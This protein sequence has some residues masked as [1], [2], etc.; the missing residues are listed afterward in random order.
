MIFPKS[1]FR[2][3][4]NW[5]PW[6]SLAI[7]LKDINPYPIN[8]PS[9]IYPIYPIN[10]F[11]WR[12][13]IHQVYPSSPSCALH[14]PQ[15]VPALCRRRGDEKGD[16]L[17]GG[18]QEPISEEGSAW[19]LHGKTCHGLVGLVKVVL[20]WEFHHPNWLSYFSEGLKPST[21]G[22]KGGFK[23]GVKSG[24]NEKCIMMEKTEKKNVAGNWF[25][26]HG[27]NNM[28]KAVMVNFL[29]SSPAK[30]G[31]DLICKTWCSR[32]SNLIWAL[33]TSYLGWYFKCLNRKH[34]AIIDSQLTLDSLICDVH[35][36]GG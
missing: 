35:I 16:A 14:Q 36:G 6:V 11:H 5:Y 12:P 8:I 20:Y 4:C 34:D 23:G 10:Q 30:C 27:C 32:L 2:Y 1:E 3:W 29:G 25:G 9:S 33:Y 13:K 22:F 28:W 18:H 17:F 15:A 26:E 7:S 31:F 19:T 24:V 21:S